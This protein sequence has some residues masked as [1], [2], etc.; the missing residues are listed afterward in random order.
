MKTAKAI[1]RGFEAKFPMSYLNNMKNNM[2][3]KCPGNSVE[4]F[5]NLDVI[6]D[7]LAQRAS[8]LVGSTMLKLAKNSQ[9]GSKVLQNEKFSQEIAGM[10]ESHFMYLAFIFFKKHIE[11]TIF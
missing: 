2:R 6:Q 1:N 3:K 10:T 7:A 8:N 5:Q 4:D 11:E 9:E